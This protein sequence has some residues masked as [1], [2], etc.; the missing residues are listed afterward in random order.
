M[1]TFQRPITTRPPVSKE[2]PLAAALLASGIGSAALGLFSLLAAAL[3]PLKKMMTLYNPVGP[4]S[5]MTAFPVMLW[6]L[7]WA[8]LHIRWKDKEKSFAKIFT[9]TIMLVLV[10]MAGTYPPVYEYIATLI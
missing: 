2:G 7:A 3:A 6:L 9:V 1:A 5:G 10:G 4:L 8:V